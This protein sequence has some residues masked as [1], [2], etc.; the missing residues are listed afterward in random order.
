MTVDAASTETLPHRREPRPRTTPETPHIQLD[1]HAPQVLQD[2]LWRRMSE[3]D[4]VR[5]G[6]SGISEARSRALHLDERAAGPRDAF[7]VGT[8]F[9]HLHGDG[10]GSLHLALP[11]ARAA[12]VIRLGWA[13]Q[14]PVV[15]LGL[16]A[17][18][19]VMLFG[20]RDLDE[21][22]VVWRLVQESYAF[23]A[24]A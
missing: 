23:A 22:A 17:E 5:T 20:P 2:E 21:F 6:S 14:H 3:L 18:S 7:L 4:G 16:A 19:L 13:E 11:P 9:A 12:E 8:E 15:A 1:Q 24:Q 10:S